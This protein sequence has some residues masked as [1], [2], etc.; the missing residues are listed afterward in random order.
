MY[1][2]VIIMMAF[3]FSKHHSLDTCNEGKPRT[4]KPSGSFVGD[5]LQLKSE[6]FVFV[7]FLQLL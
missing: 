4:R 3:D 7:A 1:Y 2:Y 6:W 5:N